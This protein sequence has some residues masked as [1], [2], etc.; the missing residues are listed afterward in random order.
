M[1]AGGRIHQSRDNGCDRTRAGGGV[2]DLRMASGGEL[3]C[4]QRRMTGKHSHFE[5]KM[6]SRTVCRFLMLPILS[7]DP[8]HSGNKIT[9][10]LLRRG[11]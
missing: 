10:K 3:A 11:R 6:P 9:V 2:A 1:R 4:L 8:E 7:C 5:L